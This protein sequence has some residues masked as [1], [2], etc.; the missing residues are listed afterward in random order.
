MG[1]SK[2]NR[3]GRPNPTN[4]FNKLVQ[5]NAAALANNMLKNTVKAEIHQASTR[6]SRQ[7]GQELAGLVTR[8][9]ALENILMSKFDI[10]E[11]LLTLEI[12]NVEDTALGLEQVDDAVQVGDTVRLTVVGKLIEDEEYQ[13]TPAKIKVDNVAN[14]QFTLPQKLEEGLIGATVGQELEIEF[15]D[16][17]VAKVV[18]ERVS[19][20]LKDEESESTEE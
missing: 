16:K 19:R 6:M 8:L 3:T 18:I 4:T 17:N 7:Y 1:K 12:A 9:T 10:T 2:R 20:K 14:G 5:E 11:E 15:T 13:Q